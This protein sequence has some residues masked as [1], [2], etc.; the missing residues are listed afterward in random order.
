MKKVK[1][2]KKVAEG[3]QWVRNMGERKDENKTTKGIKETRYKRHHAVMAFAPVVKSWHLFQH[4]PA[5]HSYHT[6]V[7]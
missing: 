3:K 1:A 2:A 5:R 4:I 7:R 6:Q